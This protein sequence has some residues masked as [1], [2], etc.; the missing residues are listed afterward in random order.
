MR[1][2]LIGAGGR[3]KF[4]AEAM[5]AAKGLEFVAVADL[6]RD[7]AEKLS[8]DYGG[9]VYEDGL[10]MVAAEKPE[11]VCVC[12]REKPRAQLTI[13]CAELGVKGIVAEKPMASNIDEA[14]E[15]VRV[16]REKEVLLTV[17]HQMRFCDE[18]L[19]ERDALNAGEIGRPYFARSCC[20]G[21]LMEQGVHMID[22]LLYL[23]GDP[24]VEWVMGA[25]G[26]IE[27]CRGTVH[28]APA[29]VIGYIAF[30]NGVRAELECGRSF[31]RA[32]DFGPE[33]EQ[34]TW[35]QK[36][37]QILGTEGLLDAVVR[38]S[39]RMLKAGNSW[40]TLA[41]GPQGWDNATIEFYREMVRSLEEGGEHR[42]NAEVSLRGFEIIHGI[43]QS[44][45]S[46]DRV[47]L[48]LPAGVDPLAQIMGGD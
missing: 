30:A 47:K 16:C 15:M 28:P 18:F 12:T 42:N 45:M 33:F 36:R 4:H 2:A 7:R 37:V 48:P 35:L 46:K 3:A 26:D 22:M 11:V 13:G 17:S 38:H 25:V 24:E 40:Q 20:Y 6:D 10:D 32:I 21:Q 44:A 29:F 41:E 43:F 8:A 14:R 1:A 31:P 23:F 5:C 34:Q 9:K 39:C 19:A 27:E